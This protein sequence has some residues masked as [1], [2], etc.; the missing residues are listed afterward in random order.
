MLNKINSMKISN[1][2]KMSL[3]KLER[4]S[5]YRNKL[6]K[7]HTASQKHG[8]EKYHLNLHDQVIMKYGF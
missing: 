3:M 2:F 7:G 8:K 1:L 5:I 6:V 4:N